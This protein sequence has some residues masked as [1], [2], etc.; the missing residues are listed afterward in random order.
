MVRIAGKQSINGVDPFLGAM[1][2]SSGGQIFEELHIFDEEPQFLHESFHCLQQVSLF[3]KVP[4]LFLVQVHLFA[5][6]A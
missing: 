4:Q 6:Y 2:S 1:E 5:L 3:Q